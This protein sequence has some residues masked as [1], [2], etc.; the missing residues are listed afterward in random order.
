[1]IDK[2]TGCG[3]ILQ[4][5]DELKEGYCRSLNK[6][7]C[8]R[9]FRIKHYGDYKVVLKDNNDFINILQAIDKTDSL[10]VVVV[11]LFAIPKDIE[12]LNKY[13]HNKKL[14]V[15]TKRDL[16]AKDIDDAKFFNYFTGTYL[17]KIIVSSMNN[18]NFDYLYEQ[19][20]HYNNNGSVYVVGFTNAG[21][22]TLINK[23]IYN[24]SDLKTEITTS[25]LPS[26]TLATI[27]VKINDQLTLLD[28]PGLIDSGN[29]VNYISDKRLKRIIPGSLIKPIT[30][31]IRT[32]QCIKVED[33]LIV[34]SSSNNLTFFI[35]SKL[36]I[37]R[38]YNRPMTNLI[39]H[40]ID[41]NGGED[42]V[43]SGLGF[44]KV[45]KKETIK[46]YTLDK[47]DIYLRKSLI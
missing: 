17:D 39:P 45:T 8:E 20:N 16:F 12:I 13:M 34:E 44:I 40:S 7:L 35:S 1:M 22:S 25:V 37:E 29:I 11:D 26:T 27:E 31:Q 14:L 47:I 42:I 33:L 15:L 6:M 18:Y 41:A 28:T 10:V 36:N 3:A 9:C 21:K 19:I 5:T 4:T 2:C 46:L 43:I 24:Y 32:L 30:Y 23:L 38:F